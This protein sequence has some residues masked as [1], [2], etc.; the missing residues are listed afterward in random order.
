MIIYHHHLK[1]KLRPGALG[2]G[3]LYPGTLATCGGINVGFAVRLHESPSK[4]ASG[5]NFDSLG[6]K[7]EPV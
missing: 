2:M 7:E 3:L 5:G 4:L 6:F 1:L